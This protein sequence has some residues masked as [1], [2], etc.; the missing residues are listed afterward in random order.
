[1]NHQEKQPTCYVIAGPNGAG[2]TSASLRILPPLSCMEYVNADAIAAALSPFQPEKSAI[3]AG[4]LMLQ[5]IHEL[6]EQGV[7]FAFETTLASRSFVP[8][9]K[10]CKE[11]GYQI[12]L[13]YVYLSTPDLAVSRVDE[14]V[15]AGGHN[16]PEHVIRRRYTRSLHNF[17]NLY[18]SL[19][20]AW[21]IYDNSGREPIYV[22]WG[23][24]LTKTVFNTKEIEMLLQK[25]KEPS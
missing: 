10:R 13:I 6:A 3:E 11:K 8:F 15:K 7:D 19:A 23:I 20:D 9:L 22:A 5:R 21:E 17:V 18:M 24:G 16:I 1:M 25:I 4:R 2:K 14:R 12:V